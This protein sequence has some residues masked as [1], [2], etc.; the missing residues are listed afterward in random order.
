MSDTLE[1]E[2][3]EIERASILNHYRG[4]KNIKS[5]IFIEKCIKEEMKN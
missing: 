5:K 2:V 3:A 4:F 1:T